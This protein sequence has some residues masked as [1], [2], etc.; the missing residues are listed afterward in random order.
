[1][2]PEH[3]PLPVAGE[4]GNGAP[5]TVQPPAR[6]LWPPVEGGIAWLGDLSQLSSPGVLPPQPRAQLYGC[7]LLSAGFPFGPGGIGRLTQPELG[8]RVELL[9]KPQRHLITQPGETLQRIAD[10]Y[11]TTVQTLRNY[12]PMVL[13]LT[14][15]ITGE[16]ETLLLI[17]G[18]YGTTVDWLMRSNPDIQRFGTHVV[19][20]GDTLATLSELYQTTPRT[21]RNYNEP[22]LDF[23][24]STDPLPIGFE[25]KVPMTRPSSV[26][27]PGLEVLVPGFRPSAPLPAGIWLLLPPKRRSSV[28]TEDLWADEVWPLPEPEPEPTL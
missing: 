10:D 13:P 16:G 15:H 14:T 19:V 25:V 8:E 22:Y 28:D 24:G 23:Y 20:E 11:A 2:R 6:T 9:L 12:N 27:D 5:I 26:L 18:V 4:D 7:T 1:M 17:A 3:E 21:L